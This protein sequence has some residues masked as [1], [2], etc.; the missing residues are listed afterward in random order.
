[1]FCGRRGHPPQQYMAAPAAVQV[2]S[3]ATNSIERLR[4]ALAPASSVT[5]IECDVRVDGAFAVLS[6]DPLPA[7]H[8]PLLELRELL[9]ACL[10]APRPVHVKLDFKEQAAV[11]IAL[12][13]LS[14]RL[15]AF[16]ARGQ[17]VW[18][19]ADVLSGPGQRHGAAGSLPPLDAHSLVRAAVR[20]CDPVPLFSLGWKVGLSPSDCYSDEDASAMEALLRATGL[21]SAHAGAHVVLAVWAR[22][23]LR[24]PR[25]LLALLERLPPSTQL[26]VWSA[27]GDLPLSQQ[28]ARLLAA[29]FE[30]L[31]GRVGF[32]L[33]VASSPSFGPGFDCAED[34]YER[35][36]E[37]LLHSAQSGKPA[38]IS[39]HSERSDS[40]AVVKNLVPFPLPL[41]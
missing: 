8:A 22:M 25:P 26:L 33:L 17:A 24:E 29:Q 13:L 39:G 37:V 27:T 20:H 7:K 5:A 28:R 21:T 2:W 40:R 18:L 3:H 6:H 38:R 32:D 12:P 10:V 35:V 1:M 41:A 14:Q 4:L 9:D 30:P 11:T 19:N 15:R 16:A 31:G 34:T 36:R 23:A